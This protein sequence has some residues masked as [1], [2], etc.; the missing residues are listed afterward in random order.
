MSNTALIIVDLQNDYFPQG[1]WPLVGIEAAAANA[2]RV[3]ARFRER[4]LPI[5]HIRHEFAA[6]D[7]PFFAPD[8]EGA[9]IHA[10]M[11]PRDSAQEVTVLKHE[12]N[13]FKG[14]ELHD[15]LQARGIEKLV[16]VGAMSHMCI[17]AV[18]RAAADLGY[19]NTLIEDACATLDLE[20]NGV[21]VPAAQVHAAFMSALAFAYAEVTDTDRWLATA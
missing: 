7:A 18:A 10:S 3:L 20:F 17:D 4:E 19:Q 15:A 16:I 1:R 14:T 5:F 11:Q 8:T 6:A 21:Q 13:S 9:R 2:A 12:V